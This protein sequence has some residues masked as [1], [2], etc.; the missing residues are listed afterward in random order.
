MAPFLSRYV[1]PLLRKALRLYKIPVFIPRAS[2]K[3]RG[4]KLIEEKVKPAF[5]K[6]HDY[7]L[8]VSKDNTD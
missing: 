7:C 1:V 2:S 6:I 5:K 8:D 3:E 4:I